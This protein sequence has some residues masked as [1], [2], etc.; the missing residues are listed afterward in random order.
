MIELKKAE[1]PISNICPGQ[2]IPGK[3]EI[4]LRIFLSS[5]KIKAQIVR[6]V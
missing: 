1:A 5:R 4:N 2:V 3:R 6:L